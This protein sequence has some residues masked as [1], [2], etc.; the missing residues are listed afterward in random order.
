LSYN[1]SS[2][3]KPRSF[4]GRIYNY[5]IHFFS[6]RQLGRVLLGTSLACASVMAQ[7]TAATADSPSAVQPEPA[8]PQPGQAAPST[9]IDHRAYGILPNYRTANYSDAFQ[10]ISASRKLQIATKDSFDYPIFFL[11][12]AFAGLGQLDNAHPNFGQGVEGYAKRYVTSFADQAIGNYMTEGIMPALLHEDPRYFRVGPEY[13]SKKKRALYAAT[14][15]F[16][17]RTDKGNWRFNYSELVG[18]SVASGIANAYYPQER[19][20]GDNLG[21]VATQ[22]GTDALSQVLKEF[23]P[24]VKRKFFKRH[25]ESAD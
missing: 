3:G 2:S 15:V 21:R 16:V 23:W 24:D 4:R 1:S 7:D 22:F 18:N 10:P 19:K 5:M 8:R 6:W 11:G 14:R 20:L 9:P 17:T 13:G 12:A 25:T